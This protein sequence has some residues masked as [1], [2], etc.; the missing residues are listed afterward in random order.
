MRRLLTTLAIL[1]LCA[2]IA[3][4]AQGHQANRRRPP[5]LF[6]VHKSDM[7]QRASPYTYCWS[8]TTRDGGGIGMCADG[9]PQYPEPAEVGSKNRVIVRI[10]YPVKPEEWFLEAHRLI[11]E[12]SSGD[13]AMGPGEPID[14]KL[15]PHRERGQ[16]VAWDLVFRLDEPLRHYYIDTGGDLA[17][18]DAFYALHLETSI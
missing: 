18:G 4:A 5:T 13:Q 10:A 3:P 8:R 9:F 6:V 12:S 7:I 15:K 11:T 16:V 17:Q 14:Y 2:S 1:L